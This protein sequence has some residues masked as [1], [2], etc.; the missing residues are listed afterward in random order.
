[1]GGGC[2]TWAAAPERRGEL[3]DRREDVW[4]EQDEGDQAD[5][6][7]QQPGQ[8]DELTCGVAAAPRGRQA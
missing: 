4:P 7:A 2:C 3:K 1:M 8:E 5:A 6:K